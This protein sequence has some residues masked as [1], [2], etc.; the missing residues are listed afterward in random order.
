MAEDKSEVEIHFIP[1]DYDGRC[2]GTENFSTKLTKGGKL[3]EGEVMH[4]Y[5]ILLPVPTSDEEAQEFYDLAISDL[6]GMGVAKLATSIDD[7]VKPTLF[8]LDKVAIDGEMVDHPE[9]GEA[10]EDSHLAAQAI[11]D[12]W[13]YRARVSRG[14]SVEVSEILRVFLAA[15]KITDEEAE[16]V[17]T[18]PEAMKLMAEVANR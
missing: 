8:H 5:E 3:P 12:N 2:M 18:K 6:V 15:G 17:E 16:A 10:D 7:K 14:R 13:R 4:K 1:N 11:A 9:K